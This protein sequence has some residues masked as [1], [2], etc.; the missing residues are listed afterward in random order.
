MLA[1]ILFTTFEVIAKI[2]LVYFFVD[3]VCIF[4]SSRVYVYD[5]LRYCFYSTYTV[6]VT[7]LRRV[8]IALDVCEY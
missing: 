5:E 8:D 1:Y 2:L 7:A 6:P 4:S 3:T